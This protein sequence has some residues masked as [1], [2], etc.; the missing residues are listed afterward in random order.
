ME[1]I[2]RWTWAVLL[3]MLLGLVVI[4]AP[5]LGYG[6]TDWDD[7]G[8]ITGN[9]ALGP[10]S[11][12]QVRTEFGRN[13]M[14]NYHPLTMLSYALDMRIAAGKDARM[15]H[16]TALL[17]HAINA[18]LVF[19]LVRA[20]WGVSLGASLAALLFAWHP[21]RVESVA[22]ISDRKDLLLLFFA[23]ITLICYVR[24]LRRRQW[25]F[26]LGALVMFVLAA[27]SKA[28]AVAIV[29]TF[30]LVDLS[31]GRSFRVVRIW[32]EKLPF[33][34]IALVIGLS[35]VSAQG[36]A[37]AFGALMEIP[38][39]ERIVLA[40]ANLPI[41]LGQLIVPVGLS[42]FY[43][44]G[45]AGHEVPTGYGLIAALLL[46][47]AWVAWRWRNPTWPVFGLLFF[48]MNIALLLQLTSF[49]Q[50]MRADRYTYLPSIGWAMLIVSF[51]TWIS[52]RLGDRRWSVV[53]AGAYGLALLAISTTRV[54][55]WKDA[56]SVWND[57]IAHDPNG[58]VALANRAGTFFRNGDFKQALQDADAALRADH[59]ESY[60]R[61]IRGVA[62]M[63][64]ERFAESEKELLPFTRVPGGDV[65]LYDAL[66]MDEMHLGRHAAA[67]AF[68]DT[69]LDREPR[70]VDA[71]NKRTYSLVKLG[72]LAEARTTIDRS[73][74]LKNDYAEVWYMRAFVDMSAGDTTAACGACRHSAQ[75][76]LAE[77]TA[78][79][80]RAQLIARYCAGKDD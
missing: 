28:T 49:G 67:L 9:A 37:I 66:V 80:A 13:V 50:A 33:L 54:P 41:Y 46:P 11:A 60:A 55:V 73:L 5:A 77:K 63:K 69:L 39:A 7:P 70:R 51:I 31:A 18:L 15:M 27:L 71:M 23:C 19:A 78:N 20:L 65:E 17:L 58:H 24:F 44:Y 26:L 40:A 38:L 3:V 34:A 72:R 74:A 57:M 30:L 75:W 25:V 59:R 42:S 43:A 21:M 68:C 2:D 62:L 76:P 22:W 45:K 4:Y 16:T 32:L 1:R 56:M 36:R 6:F 52:T 48:T 64:L 47:G 35:T 12:E 8:Y 61:Y 53:G 14:D 79:D 10:L 29:P